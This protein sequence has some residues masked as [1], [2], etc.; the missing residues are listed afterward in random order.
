MLRLLQIGIFALVFNGPSTLWGQEGV[1]I[2]ELRPRLDRL[3]K[4]FGNT[5]ALAPDQ[6]TKIVTALSDFFYAFEE[7]FKDQIELNREKALPAAVWGMSLMPIWV[8]YAHRAVKDPVVVQDILAEALMLALDHGERAPKRNLGG[9]LLVQ[10]TKIEGLTKGGPGQWVTQKMTLSLLADGTGGSV[11]LFEVPRFATLSSEGKVQMGW[12]DPKAELD[13][14]ATTRP[15]L[16]KITNQN[17]GEM[18]KFAFT[19][20]NRLSDFKSFVRATVNV[21]GLSP[22][23]PEESLRFISQHKSDWQTKITSGWA[24]LNK[25]SCVYAYSEAIRSQARRIRWFKGT[26]LAVGTTCLL[27]YAAY[28]MLNDNGIDPLLTAFTKLQRACSL[29]DPLGIDLGCINRTLGDM[30]QM[31]DNEL[32]ALLE[33][34]TDFAKTFE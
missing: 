15:P 9:R 28:K 26:T 3:Q 17:M 6:R 1:D 27:G 14:R 21:T 4:Q 30:S 34:A 29:Q 25:T 18:R 32:T 19:E 2:Q 5:A 24:S 31:K 13:A 7:R 33:A 11:Y 12:P 16:I 10:E 22:L 23:L 8:I 20:K